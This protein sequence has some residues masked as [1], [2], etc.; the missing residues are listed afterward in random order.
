[1]RIRTLLLCLNIGLAAIVQ[2][3][4]AQNDWP[5][6]GRDPGA[7]R[8]SPITQINAGNVSTLVQAW[9][10]ETR[11]PSITKAQQASKTTPLMVNSV[12]SFVP[13]F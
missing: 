7:Q 9:K 13:P 3:A 11:P 10:Y 5:A 8:Y 2:V 6:Y 12:V 1:M 4:I